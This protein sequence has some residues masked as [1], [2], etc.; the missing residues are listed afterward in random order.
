MMK[1]PISRFRPIVLL[2]LAASL[3][4]GCADTTMKRD[5]TA[6]GV[7]SIKFTKVLILGVGV[8]RNF[9]RRMAEAAVQR[10]ITKIPAVGG[11]ELLPGLDD[12]KDKEKVRQVVR[13]NQ[14]DGLIT[15]R[16]TSSSM[17]VT[18]GS[19]TALPME[20]ATF[21]GYYGTVYDVGAYYADDGGRN[22]YADKVMAIETNIYDAKTE[23]LIWSGL[24]QSTK[25]ATNPGSVPDLITEVAKVVRARLTSQGLVP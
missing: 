11:Y 4:A 9:N 15:L 5:W 13:D 22:I 18:Y 17:N 20:Y 2:G 23:K 3:L 16:L 1:N 14:I 12:I 25:S 10:Q 19:S 21:S 6:P 8:N 24:T 7:G